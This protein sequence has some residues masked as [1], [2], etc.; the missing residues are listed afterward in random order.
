MFLG[1][2]RGVKYKVM[3]EDGNKLKFRPSQ[4]K[5][6]MEAMTGNIPS[7]VDYKIIN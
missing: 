5:Y 6:L 4:L 1:T 3:K 7:S 2:N